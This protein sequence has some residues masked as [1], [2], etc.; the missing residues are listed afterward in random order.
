MITLFEFFVGGCLALV[1]LL[2]LATKGGIFRSMRNKAESAARKVNDQLRD[3]VAD[4]EQAIIDA[5]AEV[6]DL[7]KNCNE[8][9]VELKDLNQQLAESRRLATKWEQL[10][11]AAGKAKDLKNVETAVLNKIQE[12]EEIAS[13]EKEIQAT[14]QLVNDIKARADAR[15][16]EIK[17]AER[18]SKFLAKDL[19]LSQFREKVARDQS[20]KSE[21]SSALSQ[22]REDARKQR[23]RA[24]V[25]EETAQAEGGSTSEIER[26]YGDAKIPSGKVSQSVIDQ[27]MNQDTPAAAA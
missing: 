8:L 18:D 1:A 17:Q 21:S 12:E 14:T 22:L 7:N 24:E 25:A 26:L 2:A 11:Q 10:A 5:K 9:R 4:G 19:R 13:L 16:A 6:A 3:P 23:N 15:T 27:Y 20:K